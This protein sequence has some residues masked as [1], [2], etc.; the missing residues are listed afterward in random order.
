MHR[1]FGRLTWPSR[2]RPPFSRGTQPCHTPGLTEHCLQ[3]RPFYINTRTGDCSFVKPMVRRSCS[4]KWLPA[5]NWPSQRTNACVY[6]RACVCVCVHVCVCMYVC[7]RMW[8]LLVLCV[9]VHICVRI[10][11]YTPVCASACVLCAPPL[12]VWLCLMGSA[13]CLAV[14]LPPPSSLAPGNTKRT[15]RWPAAS[16]GNQACGDNAGHHAASSTTP[17]G[18]TCRCRQADVADTGTD[19]HSSVHIW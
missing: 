16:V 15:V 6:A 14:S 2:H 7:M 17:P 19:T 18:S 11:L 10:Y 3:G 5:P 12:D 9:C 4:Q 8:M 1:V 13:V